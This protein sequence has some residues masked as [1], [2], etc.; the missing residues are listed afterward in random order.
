V[1]RFEACVFGCCVVPLIPLAVSVGV[2]QLLGERPDETVRIVQAEGAGFRFL[3]AMASV[4]SN[5]ARS[6]V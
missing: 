5:D 1:R 3:L 4:D 6:R 2:V